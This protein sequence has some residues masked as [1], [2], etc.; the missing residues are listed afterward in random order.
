MKVVHASSHVDPLGR[1]PAALL[2]AWPT[3]A[4]L[5][6]AIALADV[7]VTV[8][9]AA[10]RDD[11]IVH[12]RVRYIFVRERTT[13]R[14]RRRLGSWA[15]PLTRRMTRLIADLA[16]DISHYHSLSFPR[17][18]RDLRSALPDTRIV[19]QDHADH[20]AQGWR[21]RIARLDLA[22]IDAVAFTAV[23]QAIP[24]VRA[25][26]LDAR[27]PVVAVPESSST[28]TPGAVQPVRAEAGIGGDPCVLWLGHLDANKDPLVALDAIAGAAASLP[29]IRLW[30]CW[31]HAPL[32]GAVRRRIGS[33]DALRNRV[34]LLG[35]QP[36]GQVEALLR[37][38]DF[39]IQASHVEGSGYAVIE[40]LACGTT[41][42][43]TD[44]PSF[45]VLTGNGTAGPLSPVGDARAMAESLVRSAAVPAAERR[46]AARRQFEQALSFAAIGQRWRAIYHEML[47]Q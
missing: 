6:P 30:M 36:H 25:G 26:I 1:E 23:E 7:D 29:D 5:A 12:E 4:S 10:S 38:A 40:A 22:G 39:L 8:V 16:P 32:L 20:P 35:P 17:H 43:V 18:V 33:N 45:R 19:V 44:I 21:R 15:A 31:L 41:P 46:A 11:E 9:Q 2:A 28:F 37:A 3:F 13:N 27:C 42:V 47:A 24:F 34:R 14:V